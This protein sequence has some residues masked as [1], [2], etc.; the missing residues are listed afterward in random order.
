MLRRFPMLGLV[1]DEQHDPPVA[2][3]EVSESEPAA[4]EARIKMRASSLTAGSWTSSPLDRTAGDPAWTSPGG[5][6][7]LLPVTRRP[8][9]NA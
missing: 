9:A 6:S 5:T 7:Q 1:R 3:A 2:L 4:G 8:P